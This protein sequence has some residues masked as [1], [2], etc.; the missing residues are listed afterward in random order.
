MSAK[1]RCRTHFASRLIKVPP[2]AIYRALLDPEAVA[3]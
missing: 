3:A 2:K 1:D